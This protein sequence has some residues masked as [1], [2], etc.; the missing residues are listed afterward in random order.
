MNEAEI[1]WRLRRSTLELDV[2][3]V[4]FYDREYLKLSCEEIN[5]FIELLK[6]EDPD[7]FQCIFS[8]EAP[9]STVLARIRT[10]SVAQ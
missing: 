8:K 7:L 4:S 10:H 3:M 1:R 5:D 6:L 2:L 9:K